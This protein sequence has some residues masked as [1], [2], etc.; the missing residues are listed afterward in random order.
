MR[1]DKP[2][3]ESSFETSFLVTTVIFGLVTI[4][5]IFLYL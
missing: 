3:T 5:L 4:G 1:M 2:L